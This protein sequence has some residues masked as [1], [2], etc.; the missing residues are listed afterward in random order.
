MLSHP[1]KARAEDDGRAAHGREAQ[2]VGQQEE[3]NVLGKAAN[4]GGRGGGG[5]RRRVSGQAVQ[6]ELDA[7]HPLWCGPSPPSVSLARRAYGRANGTAAQMQP[8]QT[9]SLTRHSVCQRSDAPKPGGRHGRLEECVFVRRA[10]TQ[11]VV[12]Y[13]GALACGDGCRADWT[14]SHL[15]QDQPP[16]SS[17]LRE[18]CYRLPLAVHAP[19][20]YSVARSGP[21]AGAD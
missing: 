13:V 1:D 17:A 14:Q 11:R 7:W 10:Y 20:R 3:G 19:K 18:T 4:G 15:V 8:T 12:C 16:E 21:A 9:I 5:A 6:V 2:V